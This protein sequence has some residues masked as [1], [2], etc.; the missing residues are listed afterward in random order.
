M[1]ADELIVLLEQIRS[2]EQMLY[3]LGAQSDSTREQFERANALKA[4]LLDKLR[5]IDA[6]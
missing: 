4:R 1:L 6:R 2:A 3:S 5:A